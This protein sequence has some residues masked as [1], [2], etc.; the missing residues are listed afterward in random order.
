[1]W[2]VKPFAP[3]EARFIKLQALANTQGDDKV[4][5]AEVEVITQ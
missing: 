3:A 2:Q 4:G 5:Y 1:V